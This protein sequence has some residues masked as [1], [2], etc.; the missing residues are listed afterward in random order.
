MQEKNSHWTRQPQCI[1]QIRFERNVNTIESHCCCCSQ[2]FESYSRS[3]HSSGLLFSVGSNRV[4]RSRLAA[5][6]FSPLVVVVVV[7]QSRH[8]CCC[9]ERVWPIENSSQLNSN[10]GNSRICIRIR[11]RILD[12][13][14]TSCHQFE[15]PMNVQ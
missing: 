9:C 13:E 1:D 8:C 10:I 3:F 6:N 15:L 12:H 7:L 11:I 4:L 14:S 2:A 5:S